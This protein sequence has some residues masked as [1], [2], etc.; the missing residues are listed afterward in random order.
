MPRYFLAVVAILCMPVQAQEERMTP[1]RVQE[2]IRQAAA[3]MQA[4]WAAA[5]RFAFIQRDVT[6]SKGVTTSRTQQV[7]MV[8]GSDYY[9]PIAIDGEPLPEAERQEQL[10]R[11]KQEV[12]QRERETPEQAAKRSETYRKV[13]E[14][15]GI[16]LN[17]FT[18]AFDFFPAGM[19]TVDGRLAYVFDA[20]PRPGYHPPN[21][22]AK[23]LT[24]MQGRLWIDKET[25]H[26]LKAEAELL[27][28]V[29]VFGFFAKVLP[30]TRME[31]E[32]TPVTP[33]VWQVSRFA[34][35]LKTSI[36]W[37]RSNKMT[38]TDFSDYQPAGPALAKALG[39]AY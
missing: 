26:W 23:I 24:G 28:P 17:Q 39:T 34:V 36:L 31:L 16:L 4:D 21:R 30:G 19:E 7:F 32:M 14:Q 12:R 20:R 2:I 18:L 38:E 27:K 37:R 3:K 10:N 15:N 29:S 22:T 11:L 13:R 8:A 35:D 9:V 1:D 5:P 6:T 25:F 33:S